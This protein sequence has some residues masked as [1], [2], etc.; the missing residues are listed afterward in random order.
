M[1]SEYVNES[2]ND[3]LY[4]LVNDDTNYSVVLKDAMVNSALDLFWQSKNAQNNWFLKAIL[5]QY[6]TNHHAQNH[7]SLPSCT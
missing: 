4:S 7:N 2:L 6:Q 1:S 3:S 5:K